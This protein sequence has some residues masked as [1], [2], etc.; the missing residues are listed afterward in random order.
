M[1]Y[2]SVIKLKIIY[3]AILKVQPDINYRNTYP[4]FT[5]IKLL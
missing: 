3:L 2:P 1:A 5:N 4:T